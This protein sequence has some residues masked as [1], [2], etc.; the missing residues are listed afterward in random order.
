MI[1]TVDEKNIIKL[2]YAELIKENVNI[3]ESFYKNLYDMEPL[4]KPMFKS[5]PNILEKHFNELIMT[6]VNKIDNFEV[7]Q[8][9]LFELGKRHKEYGAEISQFEIVK[10]A[11]LLSLQYELKGQYNEA[12]EIAWSKYIDNIAQ[13][14]IDGLSTVD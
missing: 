14:M 5:A 3:A 11:L 10:S 9:H 2:S 7:F 1:L 12:L 13:I 4:I 6:A 8:P